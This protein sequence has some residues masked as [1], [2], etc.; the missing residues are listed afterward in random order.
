MK[1]KK[2][3]NYSIIKLIGEG[4]FSKVFLAKRKNGELVA[5]KKIPKK[6]ISNNNLL[7]HLK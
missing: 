4:Q 5:I 3:G 1:S 2:I 6:K 7:K